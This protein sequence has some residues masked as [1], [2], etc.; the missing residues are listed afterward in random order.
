MITLRLSTRQ[1]QEGQM[2]TLSSPPALS[3]S[4]NGTRQRVGEGKSAT[5]GFH[6]HLCYERQITPVT[7]ASRNCKAK[8]SHPGNHGLCMMATTLRRD[9]CQASMLARALHPRARKSNLKRFNLLW[10]FKRP[11]DLRRGTL[12][13]HRARQ[14][15]HKVR[16]AQRANNLED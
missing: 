15:Q 9:S 7:Y 12:F 16:R 1:M 13:P 5:N 4:G 2:V 10:I 14:R 3:F 8:T 11:I 6:L